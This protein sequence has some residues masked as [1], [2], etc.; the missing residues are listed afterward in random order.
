M[1][2]RA[3]RRLERLGAAVRDDVVIE[4]GKEEH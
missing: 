4:I 1:R 2:S 3:E